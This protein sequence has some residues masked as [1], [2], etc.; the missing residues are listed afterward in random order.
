MRKIFALL[1][2]LLALGCTTVDP[3]ANRPWVNPKVEQPSDPYANMPWTV[4]VSPQP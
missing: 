4:P 1:L 3:Y 2:L